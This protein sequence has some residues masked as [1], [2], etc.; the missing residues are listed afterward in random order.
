MRTKDHEIIFISRASYWA[1]KKKWE[2]VCPF[3]KLTFF[4]ATPHHEKYTKHRDG[5]F[6][7]SS[8]VSADS[9]KKYNLDRLAGKLLEV[10]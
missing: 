5:V 1:S 2:E 6:G 4:I 10:K 9:L 7:I 8:A 3:E